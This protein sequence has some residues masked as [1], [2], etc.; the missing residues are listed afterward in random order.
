LAVSVVRPRM[1]TNVTC[2]S[3]NVPFTL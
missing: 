1:P 3:S 2:G